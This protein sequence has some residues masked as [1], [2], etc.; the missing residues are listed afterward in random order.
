M[1]MSAASIADAISAEIESPKRPCGFEE[2][3]GSL[4]VPWTVRRQNSRTVLL[5]HTAA[6][7]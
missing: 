4:A 6:P 3:D 2:P 5:N 1:A 7:A